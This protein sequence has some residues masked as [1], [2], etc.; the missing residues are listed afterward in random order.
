[1]KHSAGSCVYEEWFYYR[2][3]QRPA[4]PHARANM[5]KMMPIV[6]KMK[7][8]FWFLSK[9]AGATSA[10]LQKNEKLIKVEISPFRWI[11]YSLYSSVALYVRLISIVKHQTGMLS[12]FTTLILITWP[13]LERAVGLTHHS[14]INTSFLS[15]PHLLTDVKINFQRKVTARRLPVFR[16]TSASH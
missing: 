8:I 6:L 11:S 2:I 16:L 7:P 14:K 13:T 15:R 5:A 1:M 12:T 3:E 9:T 4:S 10:L